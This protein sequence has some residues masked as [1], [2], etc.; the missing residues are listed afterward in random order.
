MWDVQLHV[1]ELG[2]AHF[3]FVYTPYDTLALSSSLRALTFRRTGVNCFIGAIPRTTE[4]NKHAFRLGHCRCFC[5]AF[6]VMNYR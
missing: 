2:S 3:V 1:G 5:K 4:K 6:D